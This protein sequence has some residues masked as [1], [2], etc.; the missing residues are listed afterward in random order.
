MNAKHT[1]GPWHVTKRLHIDDSNG[2]WI[3]SACKAGWTTDEQAAKHA[4]LILESQ[5]SHSAGVIHSQQKIHCIQ[6]CQA[7]FT[8]FPPVLLAAFGMVTQDHPLR[9]AVRLRIGKGT[10]ENRALRPHWVKLWAS[11]HRQARLYC[12]TILTRQPS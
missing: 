5:S 2:K 1:P 9:P 4:V 10:V 6:R 11:H 12:K 8:S 7:L 3:A